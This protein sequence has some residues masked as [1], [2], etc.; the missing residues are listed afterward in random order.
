MALCTI[1]ATQFHFAR[2]VIFSLHSLVSDQLLQCLMS[3]ALVVVGAAAS[4]VQLVHV[5]SNILRRLD[6]FQSSVGQIPKS[7]RHIQAELPLLRDT[8]QHTK[9]AIDAGA[10]PDNTKE[11]LL[12]AIEGCLKQIELLDAVMVKTLP[13]PSD[14]WG[15]RSRKAFFSVQQE[16]KVQKITKILRGYI[17]TLTYYHVAASSTL[18][19]MTGMTFLS[20]TILLLTTVFRRKTC[21]NS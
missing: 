10:I 21:Q 7:F 14:S 16:A 17:Q 15:E 19:P 12:P 1:T 4:I 2:C 20:I 6:E 11:A 18:R 8:L 3:E 9:E 13:K 5:S